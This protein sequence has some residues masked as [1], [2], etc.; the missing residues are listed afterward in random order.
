MGSGNFAE[1]IYSPLCTKQTDS[2]ILVAMVNGGGR[3]CTAHTCS[4]P[5]ARFSPVPQTLWLSLFRPSAA[6]HWLVP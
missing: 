2:V 6:M 5:G 3:H 1:M 4:A